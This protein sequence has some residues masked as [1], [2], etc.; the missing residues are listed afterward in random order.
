M[1]GYKGFL[2][3]LK[4]FLALQNRRVDTFTFDIQ[5][6]EVKNNVDM[7][8]SFAAPFLGKYHRIYTDR[9][10]TS[11]NVAKALLEN[12][13]YLTGPIRRNAGELPGS[14]K[15]LSP[16]YKTSCECKKVVTDILPKLRF[17]VIM[18]I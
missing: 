6:I 14:L 13:T 7:I 5:R 3:W 2:S 9:A 15:R 12:Q 8:I 17:F 16:Q 4:R 10:Y 11:V 18:K 1:V